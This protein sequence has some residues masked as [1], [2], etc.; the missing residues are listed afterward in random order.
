MVDISS[1]D[2]LD[3]YCERVAPGLWDEP[4]N[5]LSNLAF[6]IAG[7]FVWRILKQQHQQFSGLHWDIALLIVLLFAIGIGSGLWHLLATRWSL[8]ADTIPILLF[9]NIFLL[10]CLFRVFALTAVTTLIIFS[11]YH[12]FNYS[13]QSTLPGN[14]LN[15]SIFYLPTWLFLLGITAT[16]WKRKVIAYRYFIG[17]CAIFTLSLV[18]RTIDLWICATIPAGT[19]FIWHLLNATT[20]YLLMYGLIYNAGS[21]KN[22][23][24]S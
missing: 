11:I 9:I 15:G 12:I 3:Q 21:D 5:L 18:F 22:K 1:P 23:V 4:F 20:L 10:S 2:F 6:I 13:I 7:V 16:A 19:H 24:L 17:G 8:L 14:F